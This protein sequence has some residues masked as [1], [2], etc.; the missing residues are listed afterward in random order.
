VVQFLGPIIEEMKA[1]QEALM[2][3][4]DG[5]PIMDVVEKV[6]SAR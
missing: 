3:C 6:A 4:I 1:F 2:P 5:Q